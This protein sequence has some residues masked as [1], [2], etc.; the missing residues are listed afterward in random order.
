MTIAGDEGPRRNELENEADDGSLSFAS[1][2]H[3]LAP[4]YA[5]LYLHHP[6]AGYHPIWTAI[7]DL[8]AAMLFDE[9]RD[10]DSDRWD[11]MDGPNAIW[12]RA[13]ATLESFGI[14]MPRRT[15]DA[16]WDLYADYEADP[17]PVW[18]RAYATWE[19]AGVWREDDERATIRLLEAARY[20]LRDGPE[21]VCRRNFGCD[22]D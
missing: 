10:N 11:C 9:L 20:A 12:D 19:T 2:L 8:R 18:G 7:F 14:L 15:F 4:V 1:W 6:P 22:P 5:R 16:V 13:S 21:R 17:D 3:V